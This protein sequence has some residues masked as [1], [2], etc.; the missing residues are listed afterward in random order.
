M[1]VSEEV[2]LQFGTKILK[3]LLQDHTTEKNILWAT[4]D[5]ENISAEEE[6]Q[7][8]QLDLIQPRYK[9]NLANKKSRTRDKAEIFTP[10]WICNEQN[11]LIDDAWFGRN[12]V[13]N[14]VVD[15]EKHLWQPTPKKI[16]FGVGRSW[17]NYVE[18]N[19]LEITCGEAPYIVSRY[20]AVTGE[21]IAIENRI[22]LLDRKLRV[23][24]ENISTETE[25]LD[26]ALKAV[27]ST[28]G[29]EIQGD[30]LFIARKNILKSVCEHFQYH[31][32]E[33]LEENLLEEFAKIISW[34][35]WQMDGLNG[36][37]PYSDRQDKAEQISLS[38]D[39]RISQE[40]SNTEKSAQK[41]NFKMYCKIKDWKTGEEKIFANLGV[42]ANGKV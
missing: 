29:Y 1:K 40:I 16:I 10:T 3:I 27:Q 31:F 17:K 11:N 6:I 28:Y 37:V 38:D 21:K 24:S 7:V 33:E 39:V 36:I 5:Y 35:L 12:E 2:N 14:K 32:V 4:N 41:N 23:V 13:F 34:N 20:D 42:K 26:W 9:K 8:E 30:N 15:S 22:G 18:S 25:W 19:R